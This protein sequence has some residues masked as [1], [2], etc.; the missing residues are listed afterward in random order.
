[1]KH[2]TFY[3]SV[4]KSMCFKKKYFNNK[5]IK[6]LKLYFK[7]LFISQVFALMPVTNIYN[8]N[9]K[10]L[11]YRWCSIPTCYAIIIMILNISEFGIVLKYIFT[12]GISFHATGK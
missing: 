10:K 3:Q 7:V 4:R 2:Q 9:F 5:V 8:Q 6:F 11:K 12:N 1:M